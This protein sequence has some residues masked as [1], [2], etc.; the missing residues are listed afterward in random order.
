MAARPLTSPYSR[1]Y[2]KPILALFLV[3]VVEQ[4]DA[5]QT[6]K[7]AAAREVRP[8]GASR[9]AAG[10]HE[11]GPEEWVVRASPLPRAA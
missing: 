4:E 11:Q 7:P 5:G 6:G 10:Q 8:G 2:P 9:A 1:G 3:D